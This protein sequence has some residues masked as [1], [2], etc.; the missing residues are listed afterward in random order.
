[1]DKIFCSLLFLLWLCVGCGA[2]KKV[3]PESNTNQSES[4]L[5]R[6]RNRRAVLREETSSVAVVATQSVAEVVEKIPVATSTHST[7]SLDSFRAR[8]QT[9][10]GQKLLSDVDLK[11]KAEGGDVA[12]QAELGKKAFQEG[13]MAEGIEWATRAAVQGDIGS[14]YGMAVSYAK[15]Y[16][17]E[18]NPPEAVK[19]FRMAAD[20]GSPDAQA[21]LAK[22]YAAGDGVAPDKIEAYKWY[23]IADR[24]G[25]YHGNNPRDTLAETMTPAEIAEAQRRSKAFVADPKLPAK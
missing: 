12:A 21:S 6:K 2:E 22:R 24:N 11:V 15:G 25:R 16:G 17:V 8:L 20:Q 4:F 5:E 3:L 7:Q 14:Q 10:T 1:M 13:N 9:I 23:D 19:W 18:V